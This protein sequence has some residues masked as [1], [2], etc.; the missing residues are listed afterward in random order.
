MSN[1]K[2][3]ESVKIRSLWNEEDQKWYFSVADVV[4][5]LTDSA[6]VKQYV[7]RLRQRNEQLNSN[8]GTICTPLEMSAADGKKRKVQAAN[9]EGLLRIIQSVP[10]PKAEPFKRWLAI[11]LW[12][13]IKFVHNT[14]HR[15][16][17]TI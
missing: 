3:F 8:W 7:K 12:G 15:T 10:S 14:E 13:L 2:L 5:A 9:V 17:N 4:E 16:P 1:I 11:A 6:D